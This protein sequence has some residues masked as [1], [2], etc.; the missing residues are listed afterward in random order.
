MYFFNLS[1]GFYSQIIDINIDFYSVNDN[2]SVNKDGHPYD[3][4]NDIGRLHSTFQIRAIQHKIVQ[5]Q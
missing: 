2:F 1:L 4:K 5:L 3:V